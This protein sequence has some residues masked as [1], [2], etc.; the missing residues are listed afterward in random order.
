MPNFVEAS[1]EGQDNTGDV[2]Q[3]ADKQKQEKKNN[4]DE[5]RITPRHSQR[6]QKTVERYGK[7]E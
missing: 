7:Y 5:K 3:R 6:K 4:I 1:V 2:K